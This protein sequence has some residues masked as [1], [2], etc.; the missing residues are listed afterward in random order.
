MRVLLVGN[1]GREHAIAWSLTRSPDLAQ[2]YVAPGN[3]GTAR[4]PKT[5]N[6]PIPA[7]DI[8]ALL[9]F[10]QQH[11]IDLTVVGPEAPLV[12]GL[13][14][15]LREAGLRVFG[16]DR[17]AAQIEGS[18][19]FSKQFMHQHGIATGKALTFTDLVD[20]LDYLSALDELPVIKASGLAAGKGVVLPENMDQARDTLRAIM[21]ERRFGDAGDTVLIEERM[22]GPEVSVLAFCDG[23]SVALM[24][25]A[26]D[27]KRLRDHDEGPNTGGM[28]AFA[29]APLATPELLETALHDVILPAVR[30]LSEEGAPYVGVL[31][32]GLMLTGDGPKVLE[33]NCRFGDPETQAILP[34]L[35][36]DLLAVMNACV[37]GTLAQ[38]DIQW[39]DQTAATVVAASGGYPGDYET[40]RIITGFD[41]AE[42]EGCTVFHA[43]TTLDGGDLRTAGGR[44]LA[45]TGTGPDLPAAIQRAYAGIAHIHFDDM[46]FRT[47]IGRAGITAA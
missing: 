40:G 3:G 13:A 28:G 14:D 33:F 39:S 21:A 18:K 34:L 12:D 2:L 17:A 43:G 46:H 8:P 4:L 24:P 6:V 45:V 42:A 29:P 41:A 27:R 7:T 10:A 5:E 37:D 11:I 16:P 22:S 1:G 23:D 30:G 26:Q 31:Y 25:A 32:A 15:A 19:A 9:A 20:A 35:K 47:D 36:S 38:F 44:V